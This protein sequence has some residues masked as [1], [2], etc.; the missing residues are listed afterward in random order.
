MAD[1]VPPIDGV[2][3][4]SRD[5]AEALIPTDRAE[6]HA[7]FLHRLPDGSLAAVWFAGEREGTP[8]VRIQLSRLDEAT[9]RWSAAEAVSPRSGQS[10]QNPVLATL[11][12]GAVWLLYTAQDF[13]AQDTALLMRRVSQ[14]GGR[15][16]GEPEALI[17]DR[18][19]FIRQDLVVLGDGTLLLPIFR[20]HPLPGRQWFGDADTSAVLRSTDGGRSWTEVPVPGSVGAVHMDIVPF[21]DGGLVAFFRSR[22]ADAVYRSESADSGLSW[23]EP[24]AIA[25]PNNNSSIQMRRAPALGADSVL[26]VLNPIAAAPG[27]E[28]GEAEREHDEGK[29]TA[30]GAAAPLDRHAVWGVER[31]PLS[32]LRSD[33]RGRTWQRVLDLETADAVPAAVL[34]RAGDR[35]MEMS[36]PVLL[37][38]PDGDVHVTYSYCRLAIK[39]VLV[40]R[41]ALGEAR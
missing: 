12:D 2:L 8:D 15:T 16:W 26:A 30:P 7:S 6:N 25:V 23:S 9:G 32:L 20:C 29:V 41:E 10:H 36:Y 34:E 17:E 13:G 1:V 24:R 21:E 19:V 35:A 33:D 38:D 5:R 14:D 22:W 11:P 18:G 31:I 3:V 27:S 37:T 39:H 40:P 4:R 28:L